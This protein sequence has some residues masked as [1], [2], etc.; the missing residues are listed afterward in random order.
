MAEWHSIRNSVTMKTVLK[1]II[2]LI[3]AIGIPFFAS[4]LN[5]IFNTN[6][7]FIV[8]IMNT[9][10]P[11]LGIVFLTFIIYVVFFWNYD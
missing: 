2:S 8:N 4:I 3:L 9:V 10:I 5:E 7:D 1:V 6:K 11:F